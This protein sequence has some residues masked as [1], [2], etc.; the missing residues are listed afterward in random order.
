MLTVP[1]GTNCGPVAYPL[2]A[3]SDGALAG[4]NPPP[5]TC[6]PVCIHTVTCVTTN[7]CA[8]VECKFT[9]TV[10]KDDPNPRLSIK[11]DG[12]FVVICWPKT[13]A[14]YPLQRAPSLN[15][16]IIWTDVAVTP[17]DGF[18]SWCVRLPR[19][20]CHRFLRL[21]KWRAAADRAAAASAG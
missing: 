13:C 16:P 11:R 12:R 3:V 20:Q 5:G 8:E 15:P 18:D 4:C 7:A 19:D 2:A 21:I 9:V 6:L 14:C 1:C 10:L 17:E